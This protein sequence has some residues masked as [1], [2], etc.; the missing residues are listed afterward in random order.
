LLAWYTLDHHLNRFA[1]IA[2]KANAKIIVGISHT[3][4]WVSRY[5]KKAM[6]ERAAT[7][8]IVKK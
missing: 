3:P 5:F 2:R 1:A 4:L 7:I 6:P 8:A